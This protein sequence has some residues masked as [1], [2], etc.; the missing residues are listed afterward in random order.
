MTRGKL[1]SLTSTACFAG[2]LWVGFS[3]YHYRTIGEIC[4]FKRITHIPCPSC[5]S[6]RAIL[7]L[8]H[9]NFLEA[10]LLNPLGYLIFLVMLVL[11]FWIAIDL[12]TRK[13]SFLRFYQY[14]ELFLKKKSIAIPI[15][16]LLIINWM[17]NIFKEGI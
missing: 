9:R 14:A 8:L 11:P 12:I 5:G 15:I 4:L 1:Y 6:T 16:T 7:S 3:Y 10:L 17:W 2:Y 13:A